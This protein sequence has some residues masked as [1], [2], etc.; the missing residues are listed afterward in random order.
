MKV[1][2]W[3]E[4]FREHLQV[5][6]RSQATVYGY[7][8]EVQLFLGFLAERG[9][10][11]VAEISREEVNAYRL[12]LHY[13]RKPN[14]EPLAVSTQACKLS[15]VL[16]FLRYLY[17]E[18]FILSD[19]GKGVK[20]PK[21]P[22]LLP[23]ALPTEEQVEQLL[24][25]PDVETPL[26]LRDRAILEVLYSSAL[27]NTEL[28]ELRLEDVDLH[29]LELRVRCGKGSKG[30]VL[31]LG[32]PAALWMEAYLV[33]SRP[34]LLRD[35]TELLFLNSLGRPL[36]R[37]SLTDLVRLAAERAGL[38]MKVTPHTLRHCTAT[39]M[40]ARKAG[41]RQLQRLLG[42][43]NLSSTERYT[44]VEITD[45]REVFLRCHPRES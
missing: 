24:E 37:E 13:Q 45:L 6:N 26:G 10:V 23:A 17:S 29:R 43:A 11:D 20:L 36:R 33:K 38:P 28:R 5:L 7:G 32:E 3:C 19:P 16:S 31:P 8:L 14:G 27:R 35:D 30:R 12:H 40:L 2:L 41:L 44:R 4:R 1:G 25:I 22:D 34:W 39:H 42:H 15:A 9:L 18:Q 21:A